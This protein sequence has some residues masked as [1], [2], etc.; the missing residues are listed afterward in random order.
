MVD[1]IGC[2]PERDVTVKTVQTG[3]ILYCCMV[4]T[5]FPA[6]L[7]E[8]CASLSAFTITTTSSLLA[9]ILQALLGGVLGLLRDLRVVDGSGHHISTS[10]TTAS[11]A[12]D[13]NSRLETSRNILGVLPV[14]FLDV[15]AGELVVEDVFGVLLGFFR[16]V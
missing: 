4:C 13:D 16:S 11:K 10:G 8:G 1:L 7:P 6:C 2:K 9:H 5:N 14:G 3:H 15:A 12:E